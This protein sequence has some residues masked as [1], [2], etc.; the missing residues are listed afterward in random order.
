MKKAALKKDLERQMQE[1]IFRRENERLYM[2]EKDLATSKS[3][4]QQM[5]YKLP[6]QRHGPDATDLNC[7]RDDD[8][9]I[10]D[11]IRAL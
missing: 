9:R 4:I 3:L 2:D 6:S 7:L 5:G 10:D 8:S 11:E 1:K